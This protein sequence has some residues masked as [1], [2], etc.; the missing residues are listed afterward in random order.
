MP[1]IHVKLIGGVFPPT[2][3]QEIVRK[4]TAS[5]VHPAGCPTRDTSAHFAI[6]R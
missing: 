4:L 2:Q 1:F 6:T 5:A 3:K